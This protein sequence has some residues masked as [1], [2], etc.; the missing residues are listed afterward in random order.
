[1]L[2]SQVFTSRRG[3]MVS[4]FSFKFCSTPET[5]TEEPHCVLPLSN[6]ARM[7]AIAE[8]KM[9]LVLADKVSST[10]HYICGTASL[11]FFYRHYIISGSRSWSTS[12]KPLRCTSWMR[13]QMFRSTEWDTSRNGRS[14]LYSRGRKMYV[15]FQLY[16][17]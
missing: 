11:T 2:R 14:S 4:E 15:H 6:I 16:K 8:L 13:I 3:L 7:S 9:L 5:V 12:T 10:S 17:N 1:M